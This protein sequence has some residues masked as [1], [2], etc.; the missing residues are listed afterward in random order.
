MAISSY[1]ARLM[2]GTGATPTWSKLIDVK[3]TPQLGGAPELLETTTLS[4]NMQTYISGIQATEAMTFTTNYT[5]TDYTTLKALENTT[6]DYAVWFGNAGD[7]A[8]GKYKF[9]GQLSVFIN[10]AAVN[11]V[12]EMTITIVPSTVITADAT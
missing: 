4:D 1:N 7:G 11:A 5:K 2:K 9:K 10:E 3:T 12:V 6:G 8:D